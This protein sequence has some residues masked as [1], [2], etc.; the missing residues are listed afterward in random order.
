MTQIRTFLFLALAGSAACFSY[1]EGTPASATDAA[2]DTAEDTPSDVVV[3]DTTDV[4]DATPDATWGSDLP[5][6]DPVACDELDGE[7]GAVEVTPPACD[8]LVPYPVGILDIRESCGESTE[9]PV[10]LHLTF[11]TEDAS[12]TVAALWTTADTTRESVVRIGDDPETLDRTYFGHTFTYGGLDGRVVHEVHI[13]GLLP[14]R[15]YYYQAG[16]EGAWSDVHSFVT[17]PSVDD[18]D[19]EIVFG[20]TGDS[21]SDTF[22][23]W[24]DAVEQMRA[25]GAEFIVFSGD[26]VEAGPV[27]AQWDRFFEQGQPG[28]AEIPYIPANGNH[29]LL[30]SQYY[31]QFALPRDEAN[32]NVRYGDLTFVSMTDFYPLDQTEI[33]GSFAEY[34]DEAYTENADATW[35]FLVNHRPF[36]SAS[37]RHGSAEDLLDDWGPIVDEHSVDMVFNGHDHNYERTRPIRNNEVVAPGAGTIYTVVAGVGAPLYDSGAQWWTEISE[38][39]PSYAIIR[40]TADT[41]EFTAYRLD[42]TV[43]DTLTLEK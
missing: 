34:M 43:I 29:D 2:E 11:P 36:Y 23:M 10:G 42:G 39:V 28:L 41:L 32:F 18:P 8:Y 22:E 4:A 37:T 16:G 15:T 12:T 1:D 25:R 19:Y 6:Y 9:A 40:V 24:G 31:G 13:C 7:N 38:S 17:A 14:N 30:V 21:R 35:K 5:E 33:G 27:Q 20:A 3:D 26:A